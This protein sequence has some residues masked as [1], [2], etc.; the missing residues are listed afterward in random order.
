[1]RCM[2]DEHVWKELT[3]PLH[4]RAKHTTSEISQLTP[5][6][7]MDKRAR[8]TTRYVLS[9]PVAAQRDTHPAQPCESDDEND[10]EIHS[11]LNS[12]TTTNTTEPMERRKPCF[13]FREQ[14]DL[15]LFR[16][17]LGEIRLFDTD[18]CTSVQTCER[19]HADLNLPG[20]A[21]ALTSLKCRVNL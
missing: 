21:C 20:I 4:A 3:L 16:E 19:V 12:N 13:F 6:R 8:G 7:K 17:L 15:M 11:A 5:I 1:M 14:H 9:R 18:G 10:R 2:D